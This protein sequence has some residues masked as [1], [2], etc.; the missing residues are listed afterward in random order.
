MD[1]THL[2]VTEA[3]LAD[4]IIQ[5]STTGKQFIIETHSEHLILRLQ[6]RIAEGKLSAERLALYFFEPEKGKI[7]INPISLDKSDQL[8]DFPKGFMEEGLEEAYR[9]ALATAD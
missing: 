8:V 7:K 2:R 1:G 3:I 9:T 4:L 5:L 6:R